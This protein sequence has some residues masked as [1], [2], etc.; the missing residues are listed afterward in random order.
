MPISDN[1]SR[2]YEDIGAL[3][4]L[5]AAIS[6]KLDEGHEEFRGIRAEQ[7][8]TK[9]CIARMQT[10]AANRTSAIART[11]ETLEKLEKKVDPLV[12]MRHR[13]G[14]A[15]LIL[16]ALASFSYNVFHI[17]EHFVVWTINS[18]K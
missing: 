4:A 15:A 14:G 10:D 3:K 9:A 12:A 2:I 7:A 13:I 6:A 11:E 5:A 16:T 8:S 17:L 1:L 18:P